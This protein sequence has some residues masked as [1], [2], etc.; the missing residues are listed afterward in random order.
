MNGAMWAAFCEW[1]GINTEVKVLVNSGLFVA[2]W[3]T[4]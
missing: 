3:E 1:D 4:F 2:N